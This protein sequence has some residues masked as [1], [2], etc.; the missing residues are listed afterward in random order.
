MGRIRCVAEAL[1]YGIVGMG[2]RHHL[3]RGRPLRERRK[4]RPHS[5]G[6]LGTKYGIEE[7]VEINEIGGLARVVGS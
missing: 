2:R 3:D 6:S 4:H 1:E 7:F 5:A